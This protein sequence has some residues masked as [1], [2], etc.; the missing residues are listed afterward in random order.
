MESLVTGTGRDAPTCGQC[1]PRSQENSLAEVGNLR[2]FRGV[3]NA[4]H[5]CLF[6]DSTL[7]GRG[8]GRL[9]KGPILWGA[10]QNTIFFIGTEVDP[11]TRGGENDNRPQ[12]G[13]R[14]VE[15]FA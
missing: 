11:E 3:L 10:K 7:Y 1:L 14:S 9:S 15:P 5:A 2:L 13:G 8:R 4:P 6:S 12:R